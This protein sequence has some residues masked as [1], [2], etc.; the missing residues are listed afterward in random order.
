MLSGDELLQLYQRLA[1]QTAAL[2]DP[3]ALTRVNQ[4]QQRLQLLGLGTVESMPT[5]F[6]Q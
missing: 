2:S 5:L 3:I 4:F 1:E 6:D